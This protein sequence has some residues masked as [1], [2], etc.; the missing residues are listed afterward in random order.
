LD[1]R[2]PRRN[3][4]RFWAAVAQDIKDSKKAIIEEWALMARTIPVTFKRFP[5]ADAFI[6]FNETLR[7][8]TVTSSVT[9]AHSPFQRIFVIFNFKKRAETSSKEP[10]TD[11]QIRHQLTQNVSFPDESVMADDKMSSHFVS[12][13][14]GGSHP[15]SS[16]WA[17]C[18]NYH[19]HLSIT[20][21][22]VGGLP[23]PPAS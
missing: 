15:Q 3:D 19:H 5:D 4:S 2:Q 16:A 9:I 18:P 23:Q 7:W 10:L 11:V 1:M 13:A 14:R 6:S 8:N 20:I 22:L 17:D 12:Q 21:I